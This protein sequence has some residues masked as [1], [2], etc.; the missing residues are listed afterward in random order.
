MPFWGLTHGSKNHALDALDRGKDR[1]N[2]FSAASGSKSAM[3]PF[4]KLLWTRFFTISE[5]RIVYLHS[6]ATNICG[7]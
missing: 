3:R 5:Y 1:T 2:P 6:Y 4:A 7:V